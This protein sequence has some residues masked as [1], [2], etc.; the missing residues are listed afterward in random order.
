MDYVEYKIG[1]WF[2]TA[3]VN[4]DYSGLDDGEERLVKEFLASV[5]AERG[6]GYWEGFAEEDSVGFDLCEVSGLRGDCSLARY[7]FTAK[8]GVVC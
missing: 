4:G 1:E 3:I 5:E 6:E 7:Y 2:A 8:D